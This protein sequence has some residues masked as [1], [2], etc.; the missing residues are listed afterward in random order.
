M[1]V[2]S[3]L[4]KVLH[5]LQHLYQHL[6][7]SSFAIFF[8]TSKMLAKNVSKMQNDNNGGEEDDEECPQLLIKYC[9]MQGAIGSTI[10]I[11]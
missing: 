9:A 8:K 10:R 6:V 1:P 11:L 7:S 3:L 2:E 4:R 5:L